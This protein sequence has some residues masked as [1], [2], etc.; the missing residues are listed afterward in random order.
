[1]LGNPALLGA[2]FFISG[3]LKII[4]DLALYRGFKSVKTPEEEKISPPFRE[5]GTEGG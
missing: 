2:P 4:Y 5:G 3:A 1:M